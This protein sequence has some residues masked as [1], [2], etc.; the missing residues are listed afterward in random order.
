MTRRRL[1]LA[2]LAALPL[3]VAGCASLP[4]SGDERNGAF[5]GAVAP[6]APTRWAGRFS[7]TASEAGA[8]RREEHATG[9]FVLEARRGVTL[10][11]LATPLGQTLASA[12][13]RDGQASLVT[14]Q[15]QRY[16]AESAEQLTEQVFGWR[17]PVGDL[18][19]WLRGRLP[20]PS[21]SEDGHPV[22]G[23]ENGGSV[24][25]DNWRERGPTRLTLDWPDR[26]AGEGRRVNLKLVV[27]DVS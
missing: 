6:P 19:G 7:V 26:P 21:E 18:P 16:E 2:W 17:V 12:S 4:P 1:A 14:A 20:H 25:L 3:A 27:D 9:R 13:L 24:R 5:A 22:A 10:L 23:H 11:E 15:G 8:E